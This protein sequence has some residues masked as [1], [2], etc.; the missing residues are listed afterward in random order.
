MSTLVKLLP[1]ISTLLLSCNSCNNVQQGTWHRRKLWTQSTQWTENNLLNIHKK[2][3]YPL[4]GCGR[5]TQ[6]VYLILS[7]KQ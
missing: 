3:P 4:F 1:I 7:S 2:K 5:I 6:I